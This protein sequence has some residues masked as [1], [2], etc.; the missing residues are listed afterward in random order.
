MKQ[1]SSVGSICRHH[2]AGP[3][4]SS[5]SSDSGFNLHNT[6]RLLPAHAD[7]DHFG[8]W[9]CGLQRQCSGGRSGE[10][11]E[12]GNPVLTPVTVQDGQDND[13]VCVIQGFNMRDEVAGMSRHLQLSWKPLKKRP[14][15]V[16][17][18]PCTVLQGQSTP[19]VLPLHACRD[20]QQKHEQFT[21]S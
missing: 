5:S 4:A 19:H 17:W 2:A 20:Q 12:Q 15:T 6:N 21:C 10:A 18:A 3:D 11:I 1:K 9:P 16:H 14:T 13:Q 7:T 8:V